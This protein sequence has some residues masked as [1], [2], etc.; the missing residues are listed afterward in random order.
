ME[1]QCGKWIIQA[2]KAGLIPEGQKEL[3]DLIEW[4]A[5]EDPKELPPG[6]Q[7]RYKRC[8]FNLFTDLCGGNMVTGTFRGW[9]ARGRVIL[10]GRRVT[11][12]LMPRRADGHLDLSHTEQ[13]AASCEWLADVIERAAAPPA[14]ER[15][16]GGKMPDGPFDAD[17]FRF[18][19]VEVR[20]GRAA[21][22]Y[23]L[24]VALWDATKNR[25]SDPRSVEDVISIVWGNDNNTEDSAFRQ[26]C[27][28]T[29]RR[30]QTANCPLNI[31]VMNGKVQ[32]CR[33]SL[34]QAP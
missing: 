21:K 25:L 33:V 29:R 22:Q 6:Q 8:P 4:H 1:E 17:G 27:A 10:E 5:V 34:A 18:G 32:L 9:D 20:F 30:L 24:V 19:G 15:G 7:A 31:S 13:C 2:H 16:E 3:R 12:G 23:C 14:A 28:D 11:G 26:L